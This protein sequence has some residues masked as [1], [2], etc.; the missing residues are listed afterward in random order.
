M[1]LT[2]PLSIKGFQERY[3]GNND[4]YQ[5]VREKC[6]VKDMSFGRWTMKDGV[7]ARQVTFLQP[8]KLKLPGIGLPQYS[9]TSKIQY[10]NNNKGGRINIHE[11]DTLSG[12]PFASYFEVHTIWNV[13]ACAE[14]EC[15]VQM[16]VNV[17]FKKKTLFE[18]VIVKN[19]YKEVYQFVY[20]WV[21]SAT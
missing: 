1:D 11:I 10:L 19:T 14:K 6:G 2:I 13:E 17:E 5:E 7:T 12:V 4:V 20:H 3:V 18:R 9:L 16:F 8:L 15:S 21:S